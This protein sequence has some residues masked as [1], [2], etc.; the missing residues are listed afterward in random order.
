MAH[1]FLSWTPSSVSSALFSR[2]RRS[3]NNDATQD[4]PPPLLRNNAQ[5]LGYYYDEFNMES[6]EVPYSVGTHVGGPV[7]TYDGPL[8]LNAPDVAD[9]AFVP[10]LFSVILGCDVS[11]VSHVVHGTLLTSDLPS[12]T[13]C[14]V[15]QGVPVSVGVD[16]TI[17]RN[18][19][20]K[21]F[22]SAP[23]LRG[24]GWRESQDPA[25]EV[26]SL[27]SGMSL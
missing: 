18:G 24:L 9:A 11:K 21:N 10:A 23:Q 3:H 5:T 14:E 12:E 20:H 19:L 17:W 13:T 8:D 4:L 7:A 15:A 22:K 16:A 6:A 2:P 26:V 27:V 25:M 1:A